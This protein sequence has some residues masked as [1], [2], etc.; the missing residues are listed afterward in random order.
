MP[1][2]S[3]LIL[4][5]IVI[6]KKFCKKLGRETLL[7]HFVRLDF[8]NLAAQNKS[9]IYYEKGII[10]FIFIFSFRHFC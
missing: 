6:L 1:Y 7:R 9:L 3:E 2:L 8:C 10:Y 5:K 4:S